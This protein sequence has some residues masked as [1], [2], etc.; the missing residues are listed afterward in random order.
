M[1]RTFFLFI[2]AGLSLWGQTSSLANKTATMKKYDGYI[3]YY[4]DEKSGKIFLEVERWDNDFI[5]IVGLSHGV[6]SNDIG[7]D[8]G[9]IGGS[10]LVRFTRVG[11]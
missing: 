1:V 10:R 9:Q 5:Y 3:P 2:F 7:L 11:P 4:W 8:R 6:G